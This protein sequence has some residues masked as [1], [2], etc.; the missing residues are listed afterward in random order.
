MISRRL[1]R[2]K[3]LQILYSY[4]S[5]SKIS[6]QQ[7]NNELFH[8]IEKTHELFYYL[9]LLLTE[10]PIYEKKQIDMKKSRIMASVSDMNPNTRFAENKV[11]EQIR[12]NEEFKSFLNSKRLSWENSP[13]LIK[14]IH[15]QLISTDFYTNYMS[16]ENQ[17]Y[18][19]DKKIVKFILKDILYNSKDLYSDLE[20]QSIFWNN[21]IDFAISVISNIITSFRK[22]KPETVNFPDLFKK[23]DDKDFVRDL[24]MKTIINSK[25]YE[26]I[27][28]NQIV[29]WEYERIAL[30]DKI[31]LL[32]AISE[33]IEFPTI[34]IKVSFNEYIDLAKNYGT[35]RSGSFVNGVLD[36]VI[37]YMKKENKFEKTGRGLL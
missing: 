27:I 35:K 15:S 32:T 3:V 14:K 22:D 31:I 2:I 6:L 1:L 11:I 7:I 37:K 24:L 5:R 16:E 36:R 17:T 25:K 10:L 12:E 34:P 33:I 9:L 13:G 23:D 26:E 8:S 30:T 28:T 18:T 29:N 19:S 4:F 20:E 21:D